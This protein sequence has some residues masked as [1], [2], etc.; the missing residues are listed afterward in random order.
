MHLL[1]LMTN[2]SIWTY[3]FQGISKSPLVNYP[4]NLKLGSFFKHE[5]NE[6][7]LDINLIYLLNASSF[8]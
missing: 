6:G 4:S 7:N 2:V 8:S 5:G 3:P 1:F